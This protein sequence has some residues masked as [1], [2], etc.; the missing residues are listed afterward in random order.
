MF[1]LCNRNVT[2]LHKLSQLCSYSKR[3]TD[4]LYINIK[5]CYATHFFFS[6]TFL[7]L[8]FSSSSNALLSRELYKSLLQL[9]VTCSRQGV[10]SKKV[11]H[12]CK[13][14]ICIDNPMSTD[15]AEI[16]RGCRA[17]CLKKEGGAACA[18]PSISSS[19]PGPHS[20]AYTKPHIEASLWMPKTLFPVTSRVHGVTGMSLW[21]R[22]LFHRGYN[23]GWIERRCVACVT[24]ARSQSRG[25]G[26]G[27]G[28]REDT[29]PPLFVC[30]KPLSDPSF[31]WPAS[32]GRSDGELGGTCQSAS[33]L[34]PCHSSAE[35]DW[36]TVV[37]C[38]MFL[39][40]PLKEAAV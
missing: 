17:S 35:W 7:N 29:S 32:T 20:C 40:Q 30:I 12:L 31:K 39:L 6:Y 10:G 11:K 37:S 27:Q 38:F 19:W 4:K 25:T 8:P 13:Y 5:I 26:S 21:E 9:S 33:L 16:L 2:K 28:S 23:S 1:I 34:H 18:L 24:L 36:L 14:R 15:T 3:Q 22:W